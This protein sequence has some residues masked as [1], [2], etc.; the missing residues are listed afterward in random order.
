[1]SDGLRGISVNKMFII[2]NMDTVTYILV[3][4]LLSF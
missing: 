4:F 2:L 3:V 1:M